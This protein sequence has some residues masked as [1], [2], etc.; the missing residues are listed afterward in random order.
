[1]NPRKKKT[2]D[3]QA[4]DNGYDVPIPSRETLTQFLEAATSP[5]NLREIAAALDVTEKPALIGLRRRLKAMA[6]DGQVMH[7]RGNRFGLPKRMEL[8]AGRV[9]GHADG[10]AFVRPDDN[11]ADIYL[12]HREARGVLHG[13]RVLVRVAGYDRRE[14][15]YGNV[16][17]VLE[18]ANTEIV[19]RYYRAR[20]VGIVTPDNRRINQDILIP[21]AGK[22]AKNGQ[23]VVVRVQQQPDNRRGPIGEIVEVLG[24]H[25]APG[26]EIDVAIRSYGLPVE[27]PRAVIDGVDQVPAEVDSEMLA[28]RKDLRD[29]PFVTID[30][31]DA[32]DFDDAVFCRK[33][34]TGYVLYVAI[35]DVAHY[36]TQGSALDL[37]ARERGTSVYFPD[38]VIPMLPE[39]LSNGICSLNPEVDRLVMICEMRFDARGEMTKYRFYNGAIR[40]HARLTYDEVATWLKA[41][42]VA[43]K[44]SVKFHVAT[45]YALYLLLKERRDQRGALEFESQEP[46]FVFNEQRKIERIEARQRNDAHRMIEE[47]MIAANVAAATDLIKHRRAALFRVHARPD[48]ERLSALREFLTGVGLQLGGGDEPSALDFARVLRDAEGRQD[49][50]LIEM[51]LLRGQKLAEYNAENTGHFGLA[52]DAYAHF[53][54]PIRRYPDLCVHRALKARIARRKQSPEQTREVPALGQHCSMTERRADEATRDAVA[55]LKCEYMEDKIGDRFS[56]VVS[57]VTSFGVFVELDDIFVEGL[58]HVT[59]LPQDYYE[60]DP[61]VHSLRGRASGREFHIGQSLE[62]TVVRVSLDDRKIDFAL[63]QTAPRRR[64]RR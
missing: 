6:R 17:E 47:S 20:G 38:N 22:R 23:F 21:K 36:V 18:R 29:T 16:V 30:G 52:L 50:H 34:A 33:S 27:W 12:S 13:D 40:S 14:R 2:Q 59:A 28:G 37:E 49:R 35:A 60:F 58:V 63:G 8:I 31:A 45:L 48:A 5:A 64:R 55:W 32:R 51:I 24:D 43:E 53:T 61:V 3:V 42:A 10:F 57:S 25:M 62:I 56:G 9:F 15:P 39:A 44:G 7:T 4:V 26:M 11:D 41:P 19:G 46:Y 1:M 54:S